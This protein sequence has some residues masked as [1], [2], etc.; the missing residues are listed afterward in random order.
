LL[1]TVATIFCAY[2]Y[3]FEQNW[4]LTIIHGDYL[5][6]GYAAYLGVVFLFLCD[7]ALN[8]GRVTTRLVNGL[9]GG[10]GGSFSLTP[11]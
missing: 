5:G 8:F 1:L 11:C 9:V 6:L 10:I 2:L 4:L 7:I 3:V